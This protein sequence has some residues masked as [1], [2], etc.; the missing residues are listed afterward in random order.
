MQTHMPPLRKHADYHLREWTR[1]RVRAES[2]S[3]LA[4]AGAKLVMGLGVT[5][6]I[7]VMLFFFPFWAG[8]GGGG[9]RGRNFDITASEIPDSLLTMSLLLAIG[10]PVIGFV[11]QAVIHH[12]QYH[13]VSLESGRMRYTDHISWA[14][15]DRNEKT[16]ARSVL[17]FALLGPWLVMSAFESLLGAVRLRRVNTD[18]VAE[19]LDA[20]I[21][22]GH[23]V[24]VLQL[25]YEYPG[26]D[27]IQ[28]LRA[29]H[30]LS[31]VHFYRREETS[32]GLNNDLREEI[33]SVIHA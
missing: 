23:R 30:Y 28:A 6:V 9:R 26:S 11:V 7:S 1:E 32:V 17:G 10:V 20:M 8:G 33:E 3:R 27:F 21:R 22:Y 25:E 2:M 12:R 5:A 29:T 16:A 19:L 4:A 13:V 31:G 24:P 18:N 14:G 15:D